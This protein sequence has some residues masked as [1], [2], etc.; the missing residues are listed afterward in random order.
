[1]ASR[2]SDP[3]L[4]VA[5]LLAAGMLTAPAFA[6]PP[7]RTDDPEPTDFQH[8][9]IYLFSTGTKTTDGWTG[10]L[11]GLE[12]DYG[13]LPNLQ[14][15]VTVGQGYA[16]PVEGRTSFAFEDV[17]PNFPTIALPMRRKWRNSAILILSWQI[18]VL[19][20]AFSPLPRQVI[21]SASDGRESG[22]RSDRS[23]GGTHLPAKSRLQV[24]GI[25][26]LA[27]EPPRQAR[28]DHQSYS[29]NNQTGVVPKSKLA[30][31]LIDPVI[32]FL[33]WWESWA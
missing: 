33:A 27:S 7:F 24:T 8:F 10:T 1:M 18:V 20:M 29:A 12:V 6:G 22:S 15:A 14:L 30:S 4:I 31:Y 11:P 17:L 2:V 23:K 13:A 28:P 32:L 25:G 9:Q 3:S 21:A 19:R 5:G 26:R 16:A